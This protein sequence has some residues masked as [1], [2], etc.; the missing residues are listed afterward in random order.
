MDI[1][2]KCP[3]FTVQTHTP[4]F[5]N[6]FFSMYCT[7]WK[8]QWLSKASWNR[9]DWL[10]WDLKSPVSCDLMVLTFYHCHDFQIF[11]NLP[12]ATDHAVFLCWYACLQTNI[13]STLLPNRRIFCDKITP[14]QLHKSFSVNIVPWLLEIFI[15]QR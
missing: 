2:K 5:T 8:I 14:L 9:N 15:L 12:T 6:L 4:R 1:W 3:D 11:I 7:G 10:V 13:N